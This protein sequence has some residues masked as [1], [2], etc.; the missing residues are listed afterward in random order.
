MRPPRKPNEPLSAESSGAG[1]D[2]N[3]PLQIGITIVG[4]TAILGG[5]GWWLDSILHTF[6]ILMAIGATLGLFGI[7][8]ATYLR[9]KEADSRA[10]KA[11]PRGTETGDKP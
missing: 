11:E 8:Y 2:L 4:T 1:R 9:L 3:D 6:P 10:G 7:I 5:I